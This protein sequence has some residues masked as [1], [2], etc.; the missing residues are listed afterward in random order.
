[1]K[2]CV[3][4]GWVLT[5]NKVLHMFGSIRKCHA[6]ICPFQ[7]FIMQLFYQLDRFPRENVNNLKCRR[8]SEQLNSQTNSPVQW[9]SDLPASATCI[10]EMSDLWQLNHSTFFENLTISIC[11]K[12][13]QELSGRLRYQIKAAQ[14]CW[15]I[16]SRTIEMKLELLISK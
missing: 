16:N 12:N 5:F 10:T 9:D 11:L 3:S 8:F 15:K 1:M 7:E 6:H 13:I 4:K 2:P 14:R